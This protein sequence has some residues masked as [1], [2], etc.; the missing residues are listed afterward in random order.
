VAFL[1]K[2][3][4][5]EGAAK[6]AS[7]HALPPV[8]RPGKMLYA[9]QNFQEHVDEMIRAGMTRRAAEFTGEKSTTLPYLPEGVEFLAGALTTSRFRSHEEDR[10]GSGNRA[11]HRQIGKA[12]QGRARARACG[13][14]HDHNDV[15]CRDMQM[16]PD[17][18]A[19]R[20]DWLGARATT[21][22]RRWARSWCHAP[23][24]P[25]HMN[26]FIRLTVNGEVRQNGNTSQFI[27]SPRADRI[28][29]AHSHPRNWCVFSCGTCG[30]VGQGTNTFLK[31][32]DVMETEI[33]GW[34]RCET[35]FVAETA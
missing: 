29:L 9:A 25:D 28:R 20:S 15:S 35:G 23:F 14:L 5:Q 24:V 26:L 32:G 21:I 13:R 11:R 7:L 33:E 10:L 3:G 6:V 19:L 17:R 30:G 8:L 34:A 12:H 31:G 27:F 22:S 16:R 2:E 4:L 1:E 18:P